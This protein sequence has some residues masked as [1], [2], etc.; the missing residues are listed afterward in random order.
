MS[1]P[2]SLSALTATAFLQLA[3]LFPVDASACRCVEPTARRA[4]SMADVVVLGT[5]ESL[6]A[7]GDLSVAT[8]VVERAWK[9][10]VPRR[11]K[12]A[13]GKSCGFPLDQ[14]GR[15]LLFV[16]R[17]RG[18]TFC[19]RRCSGNHPQSEA[20]ETLRWLAKSGRESQVLDAH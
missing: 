20:G 10:S 15:Y 17:G 16:T 18:D 9:S 12:I 14:A 1:R 4:Y 11:I 3:L 7:E 19:T 6:V 5:V 8:L 13:V 2:L